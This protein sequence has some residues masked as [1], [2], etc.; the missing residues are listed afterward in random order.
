MLRFAVYVNEAAML[1]LIRTP[2]NDTI[3]NAHEAQRSWPSMPRPNI[4]GYLN[5]TKKVERSVGGGGGCG[6]EKVLLGR[7]HG[8]GCSKAR[9]QSV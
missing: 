5:K 8:R 4:T 9:I 6:V 7:R 3:G 1:P 2:F